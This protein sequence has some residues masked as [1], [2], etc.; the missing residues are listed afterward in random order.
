MPETVATTDRLIL[1][2]WEPSDL[3]DFMR[4]TNTPAVMR[5][6]GG[7][8][9]RAEHEAALERILGFTRTPFLHLA[10]FPFQNVREKAHVALDKAT[11]IRN[12][13][14]AAPESI[15]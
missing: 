5:W 14:L 8:W 15:A 1:R 6:L 4:V 2:E 12:F 9:S 7:V 11:S 3:D 13:A 10:R